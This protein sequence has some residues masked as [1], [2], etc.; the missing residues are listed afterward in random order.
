MIFS[1]SIFAS[2]N[3]RTKVSRS[4]LIID[5]TLENTEGHLQYSY[6]PGE[7]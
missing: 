5:N 4:K 7:E 2:N 6:C 1:N 3:S